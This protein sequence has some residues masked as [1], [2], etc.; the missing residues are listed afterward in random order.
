VPTLPDELLPRAAR[1][2]G[3]DGGG[4]VGV[5]VHRALDA[6][7][8]TGGDLLARY[9]GPDAGRELLGRYLEHPLAAARTLGAEV[10]FNLRLAGD[11]RVKGLVD[12]VCE[13]DGRTVLV[14]YKTNARL[15]ER[16]R[17][18]YAAQL[19]LYGLAARRGLL[20]GGPEPDLVLFDLRRG[21]AI[22]VG[23]DPEDA[24]ARVVEA[25]QKI[26]AGDFA[27][28]PEHANR[29]CFLCAYRPLCRDRR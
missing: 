21:E 7:H 26:A 24:E 25:A 13:L 28:G 2:A 3:A 17:E 22:R 16:L 19:R 5:A 14:D 10:E 8:T 12:R 18:T 20:P 15:D 4:D 27:L 9:E 29:P 6:W 11:V 23:P 1:G